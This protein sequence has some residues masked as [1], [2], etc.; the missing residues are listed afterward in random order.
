MAFREARDQIPMLREPPRGEVHRSYS[1]PLHD[2]EGDSYQ[3]SGHHHQNYT[4]TTTT[5]TPSRYGRRPITPRASAVQL[6]DN[7]YSGC[8]PSP[9]SDFPKGGRGGVK[10][11]AQQHSEEAAGR[12]SKMM[13]CSPGAA[14]HRQ[15]H[16]IYD[17]RIPEDPAWQPSPRFQARF[18]SEPLHSS[19]GRGRRGPIPDDVMLALGG[20]TTPGG[21]R[22]VLSPSGRDPITRDFGP[23]FPPPRG[24]EGCRK[25]R[26][27]KPRQDV[28]KLYGW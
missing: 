26:D 7:S 22:R 10:S 21:R 24:L 3:D 25:N 6:C 9:G 18:A 11:V 1:P 20:G 23:P 28:T 19:P 16:N 14:A 13:R 15:Q 27:V 8:A 5:T 4:T 17:S 12:P 2:W